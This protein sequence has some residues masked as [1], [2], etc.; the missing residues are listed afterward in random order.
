MKILS[1]DDSGYARFV[2]KLKRRAIPTDDVRES[3]TTIISEVAKRGDAALVDF[4]KKFDGATLKKSQL[5]VSDEELAA[6]LAQV[7]KET[8]AAVAASRKN[9]HAFAERSM[10][11]D[12]SYRNA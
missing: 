7:S 4:A 1:Y 12:W 10:R 2:K 6:A 3:V 11:K 9:I 8:K 5:R